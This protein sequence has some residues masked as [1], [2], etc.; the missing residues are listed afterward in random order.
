MNRQCDNVEEFHP[1]AI[2]FFLANNLWFCNTREKVLGPYPTKKISELA[3]SQYL[4]LQS[5]AQAMSA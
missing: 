3:L 5:K 1:K 4:Y 2:R